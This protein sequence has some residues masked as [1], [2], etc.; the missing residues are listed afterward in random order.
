[1]TLITVSGEKSAQ[2]CDVHDKVWFHRRSPCPPLGEC[3]ERVPGVLTFLAERFVIQLSLTLSN[4]VGPLSGKTTYAVIGWMVGW[5]ILAVILRNRNVS[6]SA[7]DGITGSSSLSASRLPFRPPGSCSA[8]DILLKRGLEGRDC[9]RQGEC[10]WT[11]H[12][13]G[14]LGPLFP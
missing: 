1:V 14:L 3:E 5:V 12:D 11:C 10:Q 13:P 2:S 8:P 4:D 9:T 7:T 6:R